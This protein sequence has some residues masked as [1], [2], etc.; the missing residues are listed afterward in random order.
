MSHRKGAFTLIELLVVIAII[1]ILAAILF[2][3]FA[4]AKESAKATQSISNTKQIGIAQQMYIADYD[5]VFPIRRFCTQTLPL[6]TIYSWKQ[7][8][9]PY[10][11]NTDIFRDPVNNSS[12]FFDDTSEPLILAFNG[13]TL[14][15]VSR[16]PQFA[17]GYAM[18]NMGFYLNGAWDSFG[19]CSTDPART[20][21]SFN[22]SQLES[23]AQI[24][25]ILE[26]KLQWT[27]MGS[28]INWAN[29]ANDYN[30]DDGVHRF[31]GWNWGGGKWG[32]KAMALV[33]MDSHSKRTGH[34]AICGTPADQVNVFGWVRSRLTNM[35]PGG[36]MSWL[37]TYCQTM[38]QAVK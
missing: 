31:S 15:S 9:H 6:P 28:Y 1:A 2:P 18:T 23:V 7:A 10:M 19:P 4:Q 21:N 29:G 11:K 16:I 30:D 24:A 35:A 8:M 13:F 26:T 3:V 12:R 25:G 14:P 33:F 32:E 22:Q 27:D 36:D 34:S 37:D 17:R 20:Y 5:D 38:P